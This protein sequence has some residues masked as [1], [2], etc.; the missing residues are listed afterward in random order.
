MPQTKVQLLEEAKKLGLKVDP[1]TKMAD[2]RVL[3]AENSSKKPKT[4]LKET[5]AEEVEENKAAKA[6]K[7][8]PNSLRESEEESSK[9]TAEPKALKKALDQK[10]PR[11]KMAR[12]SKNFRKLA[13]KIEPAKTYS[14]NEAIELVKSTSPVKFDASVELHINLSVDPRQAEQNVRD[15]VLLPA[16]S[17]KKL[18]VAAL[19]DDPEA[20]KKAGADIAGGD[21]LM[22]RSTRAT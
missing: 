3:I 21:D 2:L 6:G 19:T 18:K 10:P 17:G 7:R 9:K 13:E 11:T 5:Q 14:L 1:A 15:N 8:S 20:A 22:L 16:G 12:R 4:E